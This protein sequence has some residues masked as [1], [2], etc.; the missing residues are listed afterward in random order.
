MCFIPSSFF[1]KFR[2]PSLLL[3]S[4]FS[5]GGGGDGLFWCWWVVYSI[6]WVYERHLP[7]RASPTSPPLHA[8]TRPSSPWRSRLVVRAISS[9]H[10]DDVPVVART[11]RPLLLSC[12]SLLLRPSF[13]FFFEVYS[14]FLVSCSHIYRRANQLASGDGCGGAVTRTLRRQRMSAGE[15]AG[16][17]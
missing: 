14:V 15:K 5:D 17:H 13:A 1:P 9:I 12:C 2:T 16:S 6:H 4:S 10:G 3:P 11:Q 8:R 7:V